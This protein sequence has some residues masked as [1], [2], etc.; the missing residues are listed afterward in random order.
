MDCAVRLANIGDLTQLSE[1]EKDA[2]PTN[3]PPTPFKRDLNNIKMDLLVVCLPR[4]AKDMADDSGAICSRDSKRDNPGKFTAFISSIA[5]LFAGYRHKWIS[6]G[7]DCDEDILGYV[8]TW[9]MTDEA[10]ITGIGVREHYRGRGYGEL[11]LMSSILRAMDKKAETMTL[12][13]RV[14]NSVAQAL[15]QKYGFKNTGLR[16]RYY[17]DNHEDAYIMSTDRIQ[18]AEFR[19]VFGTLQNRFRSR[20]G[21]VQYIG[22]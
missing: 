2:F 21:E 9:Y 18:S 20:R 16:K 7:G 6:T 4:Q 8:A 14:S 3:W 13:V 15:Y 22:D 5:M 19:D 17:T 1:I 11:L 12:E 10:H